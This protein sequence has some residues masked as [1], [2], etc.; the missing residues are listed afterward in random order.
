VQLIAMSSI[1]GNYLLHTAL[2]TVE[3]WINGQNYTR[4]RRRCKIVFIFCE[5]RQQKVAIVK[6]IC[7][8]HEVVNDGYGDSGLTL[9]KQQKSIME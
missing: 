3:T 9:I 8:F 4:L 6:K 1:T 7:N 5:F 2:F